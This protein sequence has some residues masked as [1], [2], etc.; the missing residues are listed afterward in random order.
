MSKG[1]FKSYQRC[2]FVDVDALKC[3]DCSSQDN[4][5]CGDPFTAE[6]TLIDCQKA[7]KHIEHMINTTEARFCRKLKQ[8]SETFAH[9]SYIRI[10]D[11]MLIDFQS[12]E[13]TKS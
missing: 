12:M 13:S 3:Y 7:P 6:D 9:G 4:A 5:G 11:R 8:T 10:D 1:K 2:F